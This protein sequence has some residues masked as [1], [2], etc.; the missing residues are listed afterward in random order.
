MRVIYDFIFEL[1]REA[2]QIIKDIIYFSDNNDFFHK[3]FYTLANDFQD[4]IA[5]GFSIIYTTWF[6]SYKLYPEWMISITGLLILLGPYFIWVTTNILILIIMFIW[7][8]TIY[9]YNCIIDKKTDIFIGN[10]II[11]Y[12]IKF[13]YLLNIF[14]LFKFNYNIII[15][16]YIYI[17]NY[18]YYIKK[19]AKYNYDM[20][21][22]SLILI[23]KSSIRFF[24]NILYINMFIDSFYYQNK[25]KLDWRS[26]LTFH[27]DEVEN[28][29]PEDYEQII[30]WP[31]LRFK[32]RSYMLKIFK[33]VFKYNIFNRFSK[34]RRLNFFYKIKKSF[35]FYFIINLKNFFI[36]LII[37]SLF[38]A[39]ILNILLKI[40]KYITTL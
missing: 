10:L 24:K 13:K 17:L 33:F 27:I 8:F 3:F 6:N 1:L 21:G 31:L 38:N 11:K 14:N 25:L 2:N 16:I 5:G 34:R 26:L 4:F 12:I 32:Y 29:D 20:Y 28:E 37:I 35:I 9:L 19:N 36:L 40:L 23:K 22:N 39:I 18:L 15:N 30:L 7:Y